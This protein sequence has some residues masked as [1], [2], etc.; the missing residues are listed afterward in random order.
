[1][2]H[3]GKPKP[4]AAPRARRPI[5]VDDTRT[6]SRMETPLSIPR[7]N[8]GGQRLQTGGGGGTMQ[9]ESGYHPLRRGR[10]ARLACAPLDLQV[11]GGA[12]FFVG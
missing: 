5:H 3:L 11:W 8:A 2:R 4:G 9:L 10:Q 1:M 7:T 12:T 6:M